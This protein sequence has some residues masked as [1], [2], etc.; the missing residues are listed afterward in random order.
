[1]LRECSPPEAINNS[2]ETAPSK[3]LNR[4]SVNGKFPKI[5]KGI[6]I[7]DKIGI[8]A[9][10]NQCLLFDAWLRQLEAKLE[11]NCMRTDMNDHTEL[12]KSMMRFLKGFD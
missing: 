3:R 11:V 1:M 4:S 5:T 10:R 12:R 9:M 2:L 7:A 6:S 8:P